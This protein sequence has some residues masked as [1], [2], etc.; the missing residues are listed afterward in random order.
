[1]G[2]VCYMLA[3]QSSKECKHKLGMSWQPGTFLGAGTG[4]AVLGQVHCVPHPLLLLPVIPLRRGVQ[5]GSHLC[6]LGWA[7]VALV[8][9][10]VVVP[11]AE[12]STSRLLDLQIPPAIA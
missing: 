6:E 12:C 9:G 2:Y 10:A 1:M 7:W 11:G 8:V 5:G 3:L 4:P